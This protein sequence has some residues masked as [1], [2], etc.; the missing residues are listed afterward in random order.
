MKALSKFKAA[1]VLRRKC[2]KVDFLKTL[3]KGSL[4]CRGGIYKGSE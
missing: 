2:L 1:E 4:M 3:G